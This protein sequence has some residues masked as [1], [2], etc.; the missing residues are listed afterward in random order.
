MTILTAA[1]VRALADAMPREQDRLAVYVAAYTGLRAGELWA[2]RQRDIDL[3]A[4]RL[5][6]ARALKDAHGHLE[7]GDTKTDRSRRVVSLSLFL[8]NMIATHFDKIRAD[9]DALVF[10][11][12]GGANGRRAGDGGPVRHGLF[13]R[14]YFKPAVEAALPPDKHAL[15]FHDLRH[16]C[17]SLLIHDGAS[18]LL[19][20]ARLGHVGDD[21]DGSLRPPVP[22]GG[23]GARRRP[24]RDLQ[25]RQRHPARP[26]GGGGGVAAGANARGPPSRRPSSGSVGRVRPGTAPLSVAI[27]RRC[28]ARYQR[29]RTPAD[30][31][32]AAPQ[33]HSGNAPASRPD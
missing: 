16:T 18:I 5:T 27:W 12:P 19:V 14:R 29:S 6:V 1:E 33:R 31:R 13:V 7:F 23:G 26:A 21:D 10:T 15:R 32:G 3:D 22:L 17:A 9:P 20:Q 11:S 30:G 28:E 25:R 2:L 8:V 24:R 4:R